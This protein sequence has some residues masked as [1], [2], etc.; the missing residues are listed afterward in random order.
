ML[1]FDYNFD[2]V[3]NLDELKKISSVSYPGLANCSELFL[4]EENYQFMISEEGAINQI[5][6][7]DYEEEYVKD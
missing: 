7:I 5:I 3:Y 6:F 1:E 2:H 4:L